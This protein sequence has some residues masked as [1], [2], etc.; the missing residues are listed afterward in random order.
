[1]RFKFT[2]PCPIDYNDIDYTSEDSFVVH[3]HGFIDHE[4]G[5]KLYRLGLADRCLTKEELTNNSDV[6]EYKELPYTETSVRMTANFTGKRYVSIIAL[7]NAME[8]SDTVCSDGITRDISAPSIQNLTLQHASWSESL[9]CHSGRPYVLLSNLQKKSLFNCSA[10]SHVC[11][12]F[13]E[14]QTPSFLQTTI[15]GNEDND[16]SEFLCQQL[17][18]YTNATIIYLPDDHIFLQW[19][20][21]ETGSQIEDLFVGFG[22]D[23]TE[24]DTPSLLNYVSTDR[25]FYFKRNHEAIGSDEIFFIFIK[26]LNKAG[27]SSI[28]TL[29]PILIDQTPPMYRYIP[30]VHIKEKNVFFAWESNTFYDDE[31]TEQINRILFQFVTRDIPVSPLLEWRFESSDPCPSHSGGC[32]KYP[33]SRLQ[34]QETGDG[35]LFQIIIHIYNNAGHFTSLSTEAFQ[36]PSRYPPGKGNVFDLDPELLDATSTDINVYFTEHVM[37]ASWSG[38]KHHEGILQEVGVGTDQL[39]ANIVQFQS[40]SNTTMLCLHSSSISAGRI[41]YFLIR[42]NCSGGSTISASN[43][44]LITPIYYIQEKLDI[45]LGQDCYSTAHFEQSTYF[46]NFSSTVV[47]HNP[48]HIGQRYSILSEND[49]WKQT[50]IVFAD[51]IVEK[52]KDIEY[53]IPFVDHPR[54]QLKHS[55]IPNATMLLKIYK[56]PSESLISTSTQVTINWKSE[57]INDISGLLY[58]MALFEIIDSNEFVI[59]PLQKSINLRNISVQDVHLEEQKEYMA[60][61]EICNNMRCLPSNKSLSFGVEISAP[62][63]L[64]LESE[65]KNVPGETCVDIKVSWTT[66]DRINVSFYQWTL[67]SDDKARKLMFIWENVIPT[68]SSMEKAQKCVALPVH[69]HSTLYVCVRLFSVSGLSSTTCASIATPKMGAY[70]ADVVYELDTNKDK[71]ILHK[72]Y[73]AD[74]GYHYTQL[75]DSELDVGNA[76]SS[77]AGAL[78]YASER[79]V[80]WFLMTSQYVPENCNTDVNCQA[81]YMT[82]TGYVE[83]KNEDMTFNQLYYICAF[84]NSTEVKRESSIETLNEISS[85][86]NGFILDS[87]PPTSGQVLVHH[88]NGFIS[89]P[90]QIFVSWAGFDDNIDAALLGYPGKIQYYSIGIGTHGGRENLAHEFKPGVENCV[91][92]HTQSVRDGTPLFVTVNAT[93]YAGYTV[94]AHSSELIVDTSP[95][96]SGRITLLNNLQRN[97][98]INHNIAYLRLEAFS[99]P[100]SGIDYFNVGLGTFENIADIMSQTRNYGEN[101]EWNLSHLIDGHPYYIIVQAVNRAGLLSKPVSLRFIVDRTPPINGHVLD[102]I[103][104]EKDVD[105]QADIDVIHASWRNFYDTE[106]DIAFYRV[107]LGTEPYQS[108]QT[109]L[110]NVGLMTGVGLGTEPY[111][112]DQ[113]PLI[114]VGLMTDHAWNGPFVPGLKYSVTVEAC[115]R[116]DMCTIRSSDGLVVDNS[117]PIRGIVYVGPGNGHNKYLSQ[118]SSIQIRWDEFEDPHSSIDHYEVCVS[119]INGVCDVVKRS[120]VLFHSNIF[121]S[122]ITLPTNDPLTATVWATN[123]VGM[124]VSQVSDTFIIDDIPPIVKE[125]PQFKNIQTVQG[126]H[127]QWDKSIIKLQWHFSDDI[128]PIIRHEISLKTHHDGHTPVEHVVLGSERTLSISLDGNNWLHSGDTYYAIVTACNAAGLC[129]S[130]RT[131]DL[132]IDSTPPHLGGF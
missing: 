13:A 15:K 76:H 119:T 126:Q 88:H 36:V 91:A 111:Q 70:K 45:H 129:T 1:M 49:D 20:V 32:I 7:N 61:L 59:V 62:T 98:Y 124:W 33:L 101:V 23:R 31:Q 47:L 108:D 117:P 100:H 99:D 19:N 68:K 127:Y 4:S 85:C 22:T 18:L 77:V 16:V 83:I 67:S 46:E 29:G 92:L 75:H 86:G 43:G 53:L 89:N 123:G 118:R 11:N 115:N 110:I 87:L 39:T 8:S 69:G 109:P 94:G 26:A 41:Q 112:S 104:A 6:F 116:A 14:Q 82:H 73:S 97:H 121:K 74:I 80:E 25:K 102:G 78:V 37:C 28:A 114:N 57:T 64:F 34:N 66:P 48:L 5:I 131:N 35:D 81:N 17:Q 113:T 10:C 44:V 130:E 128:S 120:N 42:A 125:A 105:F 72:I 63:I 2:F 38:F 84:S 27:I 103:V 71:M 24:K 54:L 51:G 56:C 90:Q 107:G 50:T 122:N 106:S 93:D 95:P 40:V 65:I 3:W 21:E 79:T 55:I 30:N 12:G 96:S 58:S 52:S 60:R 132:L 9:I